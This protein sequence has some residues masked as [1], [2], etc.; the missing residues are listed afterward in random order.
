MSKPF[1][2][3]IIPAF[4]EARRL[5]LT[6][7]DID[8]H[9]SSAEFS[10]EILVVSDGSTDETA[11]IVRRFQSIIKNL[12]FIDNK[13]NHGKGWVVRQGMLEA[14]G[15]W[16]LFT[17]ADNST[18]VDQVEK[19]IPFFK[20]KYDV[21]IG[22]RAIRGAKLHPPQPWYRQILGKGGNLF[23]QLLAVRGIWDTQCGFKCFSE[24]SAEKIF[25]ISKIDR[26]GFDVEA[27]VL[28]REF[29]YRIKEIPVIWVNDTR[30][31]VGMGAY[32][33]TLIEVVKIRWW[34]LNKKY[35]ISKNK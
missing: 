14:R 4:N 17:D 3:V 1:L 29:G 6:L 31:T 23:I 5:P 32:V 26:W 15:N 13:E 9:L 33:S 21:V 10:S 24:E 7:V 18:S 2:S 19:M 28:A 16:R 20:E 25:S 11:D 12:R 30:S 22:S 8:R 34:L 27:L 35:L